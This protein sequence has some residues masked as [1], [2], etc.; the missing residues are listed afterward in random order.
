MKRITS[1]SSGRRWG[2]VIPR[3]K[4]PFANL[5]QTIRWRVFPSGAENRLP[6]LG[7]SR[8]GTSLP[9]ED[10]A[11]AKFPLQHRQQ[12]RVVPGA[13]VLQSDHSKRRSGGSMFWNRSPQHPTGNGIAAPAQHEIDRRRSGVTFVYTKHMPDGL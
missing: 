10:D 6:F 9:L 3:R 13:H 11:L 2:E 12:V 4:I 7:P 8:A 1:R 5:R